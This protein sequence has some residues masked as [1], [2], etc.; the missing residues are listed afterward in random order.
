MSD[1]SSLDFK[2]KDAIPPKPTVVSKI[3]QHLRDIRAEWGPLMPAKEHW[4]DEYNFLPGRCAGQKV[5]TAKS[6]VLL[7]SPTSEGGVAI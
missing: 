5:S 2:A 4:T 7:L 6:E 1:T 3:K